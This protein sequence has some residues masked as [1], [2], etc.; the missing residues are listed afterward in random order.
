MH[1]LQKKCSSTSILVELSTELQSWLTSLGN[2]KVLLT[3]N[4]LRL[5]LFRKLLSW[6]SQSCM[7]ANSRCESWYFLILLRAADGQFIP[8]CSHT[9][10]H[11]ADGGILTLLPCF[12]IIRW[13]L[14]G[15]TFLGW[16]NPEVGV[17]IH[18]MPTPTWGHM[19]IVLTVMGELLLVYSATPAF[20]SL[21]QEGVMLINVSFVFVDAGDSPDSAAREGLIFEALDFQSYRTWTIIG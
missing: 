11:W 4:L 21:E 15:L 7:D 13:H 17:S 2:Q 18:T 19:V 5:K 6:T 8:C 3:W 12:L 9:C 16:S 14:R 10:T 1:A 20:D